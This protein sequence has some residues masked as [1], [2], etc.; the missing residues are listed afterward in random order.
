[1]AAAPFAKVTEQAVSSADLTHPSEQPVPYTGIQYVAIPEFQAIGTE[2][3]QN[4]AAT[5]NGSLSIDA[6]L[7]RSQTQ[8]AQIMQQ[9]GYGQ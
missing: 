5:L 3:G 7:A 1:L 6:A 2:V 9:A 8:T 4:V